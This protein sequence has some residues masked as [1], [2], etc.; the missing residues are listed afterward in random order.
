MREFAST[1]QG[2]RSS[3]HHHAR[4]SAQDEMPRAGLSGLP[5][6][7]VIH[8][9]ASCACGGACP[10]CQAKP[11]GVAVS[12]P[13]DSEEREADRMADTV[14]RMASSAGSARL[15]KGNSTGMLPSSL[16]AGSGRSLDSDTRSFMESRFNHNFSGVRI[17]NDSRAAESARSLDALAYTYGNNVVFGSG[18]YDPVSASG[19]HLLAHELAHV[20]QQSSGGPK[21]ISRAT[22]ISG[23]NVTI[24]YGDV[25]KVTDTP[26]DI[27]RRIEVFTGKPPIPDVVKKIIA[28]AY[29]QQRWLLFAL[30]ILMDNTNKA[31]NALGRNNAV[32][33]LIDQAAISKTIPAA[34][35]DKFAEVKKFV[36][37]VMLTSG[38]TAVAVAKD[39][40]GPNKTD[41]AAITKIFNPA[42]EEG[43]KNPFD[44]AVFD[45]KMNKL[46][47][48]YLKQVDPGVWKNTGKQSMTEI[49]GIGDIILDEAK[50][51]F[52]PYTTASSASMFH[53][54][55][56][57]KASKNIVDAN[58]VPANEKQRKDYVINRASKILWNQDIRPPLLPEKDIF[59]TV[60]Y[61]DK[62]D[63]AYFDAL[64]EGIEKDPV[65][66]PILDRI[67][68][69][70]AWKK[71]S[72]VKTQIGI[73]SEY[74]ATKTSECKAR[75]KTIDILCH[76]VLHA[77]VH[78][79]FERAADKQGFAQ[80]GTEGFTEVLGTE[81]F[82]K[83]IIM[84]AGW[85]PD[86]KVKLESG[87]LNTPCG[88]PDDGTIDYG[89]AGAGAEEIRKKIDYP[90]MKA[91]Y[92]L[93]RTDLAGF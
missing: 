61:N 16:G 41:R 71:E 55:S 46:L 93:G 9:K 92:F 57:W 5:G 32:E 70:T 7:L 26:A 12:Q 1:T 66:Q 43:D 62:R 14:M 84:K 89:S 65:Q 81:L 21:K 30:D 42:D 49:E 28:L 4:S 18:R 63:S 82:N 38:W 35:K 75:W 22:T 2:E 51:Y 69:H 72:G 27:K 87:L 37:E 67:V 80:V 47:K 23:Q 56:P 13:H 74:D 15:Q 88:S 52:Y 36:Q 53:L 44:K 59:K 73:S 39:I 79:D 50:A 33:R 19:K 58:T 86:F 25:M 11:S 83:H 85:K 34:D 64:V 48:D 78:P 20:V 60:H 91:A 40:T 17:H 68:Q 31:H 54:K 29:D 90:A 77:L 10:S 45:Q 8:R 3:E 24:D 76:E 6:S